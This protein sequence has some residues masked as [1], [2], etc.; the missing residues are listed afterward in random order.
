MSLVPNFPSRLRTLVCAA[1]LATPAFV[2]AQ[3][4]PSGAL[5]GGDHGE[6]RPPPPSSGPVGS[7]PGPEQLRAF[8]R[9]D[10]LSRFDRAADPRT[11]LLSQQEAQQAGWG[12]VVEHFQEMDTGRTG[13]LD[14]QEVWDYVERHAP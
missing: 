12:Y 7:N 13:E 10:M 6:L 2:L 4:L 9:Q 3:T 8:M 14:F 11:H 5:P 1:L